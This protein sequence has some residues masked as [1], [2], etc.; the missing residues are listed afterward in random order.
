MDGRRQTCYYYVKNNGKGG[1]DM[2]KLYLDNIRWLTIVLVVLYH[3]IY[4]YNGVETAGVIGPLSDKVQYQDVFLYVV[5][6]WF[7]VL[8]FLRS[9]E[10]SGHACM[11]IWRLP[12]G[13]IPRPLGR[14]C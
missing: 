9:N 13:Q 5:Y 14:T 1:N 8:L 7:M 6:P 11:S 10:P 4:M 12:Q 2:R 3:V